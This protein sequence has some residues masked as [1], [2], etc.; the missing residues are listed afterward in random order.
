MDQ[1]DPNLLDALLTEDVVIEGADFHAEG[2]AA[3][4][5]LHAELRTLYVATR[6]EVHNQTVV[7]QGDE[8]EG[9]TYCTATIILPP[10]AE[11]EGNQA[12]VW[13]I[14]YQ[15]RFTRNANGW[16]ISH[17]RLVI[18]WTEMRPVSL[19]PAQRPTG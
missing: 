5:E 8:A 11:T 10:A 4:K 13:A 3:A 18:D 16:H 17:R 15:D 19:S 7:V 2:L 9:E 14:R 1:S 6:H 12:V